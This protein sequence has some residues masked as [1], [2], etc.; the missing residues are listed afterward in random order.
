[1]SLNVNE[2]FYTIQGEGLNVGKPS[3]FVRLQGCNL[4]CNF[5]DTEF[6]TGKPMEEEYIIQE[7]GKYNCGN[8]VLTG[9]EPGMQDL[10]KFASLT[11]E[12]G[13]YTMVETNGMYDLPK[14]HLSWVCVSPKTNIKSIVIRNPDEVKFVVDKKDNEKNLKM[15]EEYHHYLRAFHYW[16]SPMNPGNTS[17][18]VGN[19]TSNKVCSDEQVQYAVELVKS[20]P[21]WKL[22]LQTHKYIGV[23]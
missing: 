3:V 4:S 19:V 23:R 21:E 10:K 18:G 2:I 1:M 16:I 22:N 14:Y 6:N 11:H 8:I 5:C 17:F 9:G 15:M 12:Y 20:N 13:Y 7:I